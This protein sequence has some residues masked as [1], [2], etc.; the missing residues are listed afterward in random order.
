L[1]ALIEVENSL[2]QEQTLYQDIEQ[3]QAVLDNHIKIKNNHADLYLQGETTIDVFLQ[4]KIMALDAKTKLVEKQGDY[5][6][7]RVY[8]ALALG[9]PLENI[10]G[11]TNEY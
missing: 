11:T 9:E 5:L 1:Q 10:T 4:S 3:T 8:F 2:T 7:N 6:K